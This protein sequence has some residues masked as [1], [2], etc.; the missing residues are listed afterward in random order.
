MKYSVFPLHCPKKQ[1][2]CRQTARNFKVVKDEWDSFVTSNLCRK[3][4][5]IRINLNPLC[6][7]H[8]DGINF[9]WNSANYCLAYLKSEFIVSII[10][11][12][13]HFPDL[14]NIVKFKRKRKKIIELSGVKLWN[15]KLKISSCIDD[16]L[17]MGKNFFG[18][19]VSLSNFFALCPFAFIDFASIFSPS[20]ASFMYIHWTAA[21]SCFSCLFMWIKMME[22]NKAKWN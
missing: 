9:H 11:E 8:P 6:P 2:R 13:Q 22:T 21:E 17:P 1:K 18:G 16:K 5:K 19:F 4:L 3:N 14:K 7:L 20:F 12:K 10:K 15:T